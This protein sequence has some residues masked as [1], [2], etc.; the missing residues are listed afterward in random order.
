MFRRFGGL[1][2]GL[3]I[4][5]DQDPFMDSRR[6]TALMLIHI[7]GKGQRINIDFCF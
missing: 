2:N 6:A 1:F 5:S 7:T 3:Y 4:T